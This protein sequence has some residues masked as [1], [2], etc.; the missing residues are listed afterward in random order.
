M[1]KSLNI[2]VFDEFW[3]ASGNWVEK[4]WNGLL[5]VT[6]IFYIGFKENFKIE[7]F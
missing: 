5:D 6:G 1:N 4:R 7:L 3:E 2:E